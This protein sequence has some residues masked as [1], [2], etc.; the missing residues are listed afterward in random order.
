MTLA[1][2][3]Y[4]Q[5]QV[6]IGYFVSYTESDLVSSGTL[7]SVQQAGYTQ[8]RTLF[9]DDVLTS[10]LVYMAAYASL[11]QSVNYAGSNTCLTMNLKSLSGI[12]PDPNITQTVYNNAKICG[13]DVYPSIAGVAKCQSF[14]ANDFSD[15]QTNLQ[16]FA[17]ALR[18]AYFNV[19]AQTDT[20]IPQTENGMNLIKGAI[21]AVC[22][23]FVSNGFLA[24]GVWTSPTT[25]GNQVS[26]LQNV[27]QFGYYIY[28][29][30]ISQQSPANRSARIAPPIQIA[31][32]YAGAE[33][34][35]SVIVYV[36][37]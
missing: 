18:V 22:Q 27:A 7:I 30:P 8:S 24:P 16:A 21:Q 32:K 15:N 9:Y 14:G 11:L 31:A 20:K 36:N 10:A 25:F 28:S 33:Q 35:G 4:I 12:S 6:M 1:T 2:A 17:A 19:L 3:A 13:A 34:T 5:S 26:L 29:Q 37:P 23:Q